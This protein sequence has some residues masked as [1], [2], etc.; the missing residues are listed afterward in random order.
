MKKFLMLFIVL[1]AMTISTFGQIY[2]SAGSNS[3]IY[4]Y[5]SNV[6]FGTINN[7]STIE[8]GGY[9]DFTVYSNDVNP[10][11]A[12]TL[13]ITVSNLYTS[14][15]VEVYIDWNQDGDFDDIDE[16]YTTSI[17][18]SV[19]STSI[20]APSTALL[21]STTMRII[22]YDYY[23]AGGGP[24]TIVD[25]G[26]AEDYTVNVVSSGCFAD[27]MFT[28]FQSGASTADFSLN[29]Q[30]ASAG[31]YVSW[32][33]GDGGSASNTDYISY[34]YSNDGTYDVTC[35]VTD[36]NNTSCT[37][38]VTNTITVISSAGA[39]CTN[40]IAYEYVNDPFVSDS[41]VP[42]GETW[43][44]FT[45]DTVS[46]LVSVSLMNS[47]Y[48]TKVEVWDNCG[49]IMIGYNDDYN[50]FL[51]SQI[52]FTYLDLGTYYVK[53]YGYYGSSGNYELDIFSTDTVPCFIDASFTWWEENGLEMG[54]YTNYIY[55]SSG[56][57]VE[58][59][60]GDGTTLSGSD[61]VYHTYPASGS[62]FVEV[63]VEDLNNPNCNDTQGGWIYTSAG[64]TCTIDADF[65]WSD[66]GNGEYS[67][68][69]Y[70]MY[71]NT[72]YDITWDL[73]DGTIVSGSDMISHTYGASGS[74]TVSCLIEDLSDSTCWDEVINT[75][76]VSLST[77]C[78]ADAD[79]SYNDLG[80]MTFS[81]A[82]IAS[83]NL[84]DFAVDWSFDDGGSAYGLSA[85]H[86][87]AAPGTYDVSCFVYSYTDSTCSDLMTYT[88]EI[89]AVAP[90][91]EPTITS[92][93]HTILVPISANITVDGV[94]ISDGSYI[95]VF[96][97]DAI[98]DLVCGGYA[99]YETTSGNNMFITAWGVDA[100]YDGFATGEEFKWKIWD[101]ATA[102]EFDADATYDLSG[103]FPNDEYF[104]V[105][106][107]S[108]IASISAVTVE[109]QDI[110]INSGWNIISTYINPFEASVDSVFS[111]IASEVIIVKNG[112]G[113]VY[114]PLYGINSIG[115]LSIGEGYQVK[116]TTTQTLTVVGISVVPETTP[117]SIPLGW[118][119]FG[120]LRQSASSV[121]TMLNPIVG[122]IIIV[123]NAMGLVY[124]PLYGI[125][126]IGDLVPGQGY[127]I[128]TDLAVT[129]TYPANSNSS[130]SEIYLPSPVK[131]TETLNTGNNMILGIPQ[132]AWDITPSLNSEIAIFNQNGDLLGSSVYTG[133]NL[134]VAIW[135]DDFTTNEIE[136]IENGETYSIV[137]W[138]QTT[139]KE[140][141][142]E[143]L[144]W[145]EGNEI[146]T[147]NGISVVKEFKTSSLENTLSALYQNMPNPFSTTTK[148]GFFL[149]ESSNVQI[150][151]Y[152]AIGELLEVLIS[153]NFEAGEHF[154]EF[155]SENYSSGSYFYKIETENLVSTKSMLIQ[156]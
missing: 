104:V 57:Y 21:G 14:D 6:D 145:I 111:D 156:K 98:G 29:T 26:E 31:Y 48:D 94:A 78:T 8:T 131:Y 15:V 88:I 128:K 108:G 50:N 148:I 1:T 76:Q 51:Q 13:F 55:N 123:K 124:W 12:S 110:V 103:A 112:M 22:L 35:I 77:S 10:I 129:L 114:W 19:F 44:Y 87:F 39:F 84:N 138:D 125:N 28:W 59:T 56:Y 133:S 17:S 95:G 127:Q 52:D 126:A 105:N 117:I 119:I 152:D 100:G 130:K 73:G 23:Y 9:S 70:Y 85:T 121:E 81:F 137:L 69:T 97:Y 37:D 155:N 82:T 43:Y 149:A 38:T 45:V 92:T 118:S 143:V 91:P 144:S 2:C 65:T 36:L 49:G 146:F 106:G 135:G 20:I 74:Y 4:E 40:A 154:I 136:G 107:M 68:F 58:W 109:T 18:G 140:Y 96:F 147:N 53:V 7:T 134:S 115:D 27:A 61:Y 63:Y 83:I 99:Y 33:F 30:F 3:Q 80:N 153:E 42:Y 60:F 64:T 62:Y 93:N 89:S 24:C 139:N 25:Y 141:Q 5:I 102:T 113:M 75:V 116:M 101:F 47:N 120:Y 79:F 11:V 132:Q 90:W 122:N 142:L 41:I 66:I 32:D 67:F 151:I 71:S 72:S 34:S 54:M 16:S 46:P 86:T 150:K